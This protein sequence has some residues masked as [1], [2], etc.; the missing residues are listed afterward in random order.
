MQLQTDN[1]IPYNITTSNTIKTIILRSPEECLRA[2]TIIEQLIKDG[3][4]ILPSAL[5]P[6][7]IRISYISKDIYDNSLNTFTLKSG[8]IA[9]AFIN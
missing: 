4:R 9:N 6:N 1:V 5:Y 7:E 3:N 2:N 8:N